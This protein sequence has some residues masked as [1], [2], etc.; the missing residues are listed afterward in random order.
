[1]TGMTEKSAKKLCR[2]LTNCY[3]CIINLKTT[4]DRYDYS[5][6]ISTKDHRSLHC[7]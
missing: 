5:G 2:F 1:M 3:L 7:S 6:S 4:P